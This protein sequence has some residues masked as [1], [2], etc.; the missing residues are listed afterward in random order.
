MQSRL[1][2]CICSTFEYYQSPN[3]HTNRKPIPQNLATNQANAYLLKNKSIDAGS[4]GK[5][6]NRECDGNRQDKA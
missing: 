5:D 1:S 6:N 3:R 2:E 4:A